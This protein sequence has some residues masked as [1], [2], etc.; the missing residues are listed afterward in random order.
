MNDFFMIKDEK[1]MVI[2]SKLFVCAWVF[3]LKKKAH[4]FHTFMGNKLC[5]KVEIFQSKK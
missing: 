2:L 4:Y 5:K 3:F 1:S